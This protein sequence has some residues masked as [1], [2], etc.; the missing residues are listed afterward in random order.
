MFIQVQPGVKWKTLE[1]SGVLFPPEYTSHGVKVLYDGETVDL[2][3]EQ[4]EVRH[5]YGA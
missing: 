2:T 4:E 1:H 3:L 5:F